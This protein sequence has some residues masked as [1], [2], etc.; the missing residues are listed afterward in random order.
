MR[1]RTASR[2][3]VELPTAAS[4]PVEGAVNARSAD[5]TAL[6]AMRSAVVSTWLALPGNA[7]S[8]NGLNGLNGKRRNV[9]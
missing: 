4:R 5:P 7:E 1:Q 2:T 3:A 8:N 6:G 9:N